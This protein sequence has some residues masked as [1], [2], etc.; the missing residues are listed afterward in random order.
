MILHLVQFWDPEERTHSLEVLTAKQW[1]DWQAYAA[2]KGLSNHTYI[3]SILL[4]EEETGRLGPT[5][6]GFEEL[7]DDDGAD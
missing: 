5:A 7:G 4:T 2:S 6:L 1:E 3:T